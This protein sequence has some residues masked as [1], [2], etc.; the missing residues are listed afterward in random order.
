VLK[1]RSEVKLWS[2]YASA[3]GEQVEDQDYKRDNQQQMNQAASDM[4]A[5]PKKPQNE[6]DYQNRPKQISHIS[7]FLQRDTRNPQFRSGVR[8]FALD[9][10]FPACAIACALALLTASRKAWADAGAATLPNSTLRV[11]TF[12]P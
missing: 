8:K 9:Y 3:P 6:N 12:R 2:D 4:E 1:S 10:S 5:E 11:V 7:L